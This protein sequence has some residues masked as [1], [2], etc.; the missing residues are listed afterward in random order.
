MQKQSNIYV[1]IANNT[2]DFKVR[3]PWRWCKEIGLTEEDKAVCISY[4][5]NRLFIE[6]KELDL[7]SNLDKN[8]K[9][10]QIKKYIQ[11]FIEKNSEYKSLLEKMDLTS[12]EIKFMKKQNKLLMKEI[13]NYFDISN[14]TVKRYMYE[15]VKIS[16]VENIKL[17][18][19]QCENIKKVNI[20]LSKYVNNDTKTETITSTLKIPTSFAILLLEGKDYKE[21]GIKTA[22]EIFDSNVNIPV[23]LEKKNDKIFII[24]D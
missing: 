17:L 10:L 18:P 14:R 15:E 1:T 20:M 11:V 5:D 12:E 6:K 16:D 13:E 3:I 8:N 21:L 9:I 23:I 24:K 19:K 7:F 4:K 22:T 2:A